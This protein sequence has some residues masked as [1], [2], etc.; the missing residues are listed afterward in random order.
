MKMNELARIENS[1]N[2]SQSRT[3]PLANEIGLP[4]HVSI[5]RHHVTIVY[6]LCRFLL[7][8]K[9][10]FSHSNFDAIDAGSIDNAHQNKANCPNMAHPAGR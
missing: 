5:E 4:I 3:P 9:V 7:A 10:R 1:S 6:D 8:H 2:S